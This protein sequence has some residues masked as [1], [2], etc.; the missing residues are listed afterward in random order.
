MRDELHDL[1]VKHALTEI[2]LCNCFFFHSLCSLILSG[3]LFLIQCMSTTH[4]TARMPLRQT[5]LPVFTV[6]SNK[7][8]QFSNKIS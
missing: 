4:N 2:V 7:A 8:S 6:V 5:D 1:S 3:T